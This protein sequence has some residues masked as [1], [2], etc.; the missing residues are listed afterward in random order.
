MARRLE[1]EMTITIQGQ[2][3]IGIIIT[4]AEY[5]HLVPE[6]STS[7]FEV[8]KESIFRDGQHIPIIINPKGEILD[9]HTR[10]KA[11]NELGI[12]PR[13]MVREFEDPLAEKK[14]IIDINRNR[15]H[16]NPFQRIELEYK[17]EAIESELAKRRML[18]GRK[19]PS[20]SDDGQRV[21]TELSLNSDS[22]PVQDSLVQNYT[23]V[24]EIAR[25]GAERE[26]KKKGRVIDL[27]AVR[28]N[29]SPMTYFMGR[30]I[31]KNSHSEE[32]LQR[33]REGK[34]KISK[35]YRYD[36][37][38][39]KR[40]ALRAEVVTILPEG[41]RLVLGDFREKCKEI[42]DNSIDLIFTDPPYDKESLP[43]YEWLG[44]M[45]FRT[46]K[47]GGV[48]VTYFGQYA[49]GQVC[50][51]I[52]SSGLRQNWL[53]Y[54]HHNGHSRSMHENHV[55]VN[56]KP[57]L[58]FVKGPELR[59]PDFMGD[60]IESQPPDKSLHEW[61]QSPIE[62]EHVISKRTV[63]NDTI[64]DPFMGSGTT[65]LAA[66]NLQRQFIGI[67]KDSERFE[68]AKARIASSVKQEAAAY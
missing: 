48:L 68:I 11:C 32:E 8:L 35:V 6:L 21:S 55:F 34:L 12:V 16:L 17:Y 53:H 49:V 33:L 40:E 5:I 18:V 28:A 54:V 67:E 2:D 51:M 64:L 44:K 9:G 29:V 63:E 30:E 10:F 25:Q 19:V 3:H 62:A 39:K 1:E 27:S 20:V 7:E 15:R 47:P 24:Q 43:L 13:A 42:P 45:A 50:S 4:N 37:K 59:T 41:V 57:L 38:Q 56:G 66:M 26:Q 52:E 23:R 61:A 22:S 65:G 14:F 60:F 31:I 36:Q 46:L 58:E